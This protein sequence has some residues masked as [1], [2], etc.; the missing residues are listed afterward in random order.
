MPGGGLYRAILAASLLGGGCS[1]A[2][3]CRSDVSIG[4]SQVAIV[5][6]IDTIAPGVQTTIE[7]ATSLV[8]GERVTLEILD[9][10]G[11]SFG[12]IDQP[13]DAAGAAVFGEV[14]V[15][16]PRAVLRAT[17]RGR[18]GIGRAEAAVD[19]VANAGCAVR[20]SPVPEANAHFAP[21]GVLAIRSD[22]DPV[23]PGYQAVV[24]VA[25]HPGWRIQLFELGSGELLR[26]SGSAGDDGIAQLPVTVV[27]GRVGF[28]AVC[29]GAGIERASP[30]TTVIVDTIAPTCALIAP[31]PG[32]PITA[33]LDLNHD[34]SDGVQLAVAARAYGD[35]VGRE[36]VTLSIGRVGAM[37]TPVPAT[38]TDPDGET[39]AAVTLAP[40]IAPAAYDFA[41]TL[42]DHAGNV[43]TA[44][45]RFDVAL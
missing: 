7:V 23:E 1:E 39:T 2:A 31:P 13:V 37:A 20:L 12:S 8:T 5:S 4:F 26:A 25:T 35:D 36:P 43:C 15:P 19:V 29:R 44:T 11:R 17:G 38:D 33:A 34:P 10:S 32:S 9:A 22:L 27:D 28:R 40:A 42:R 30:T 24:S 41:I 45:A 16:E 6:D 18:C 14:S 3:V 21:L